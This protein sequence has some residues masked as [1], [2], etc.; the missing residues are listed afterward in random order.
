MYTHCMHCNAS[1][2]KNEVLE[3]FP[4]GERIAFD[5]NK[6]RLWVVCRK[7]E[8]W[9]LAPF[10]SRWEAIEQAERAYRSTNVRMATDNIGLAKWRDG[11]TLVRVGRPLRPEFAAWRYGDQFGRRRR[12]TLIGASV[13]AAGGVALVSGAVVSGVGLALLPLVHAFNMTMMVKNQRAHFTPLPHPDGDYFLPFGVPKLIAGTRGPDD[14]AIELGWVRRMPEPRMT[15]KSWIG[16]GKNYEQGR[17]ILTDALAR[18]ALAKL[19]V[20]VNSGGASSARVQDAVSMIENAGGP[21]QMMSWA[22]AQRN[23][24]GAKQNFGD[25]GDLQYIPTEAR[26]AI[27]MSVH[28]ERE[29]LALLGELAEL[30]RAWMDAERIANISDNLLVDPV[31]QQKFETMRD[32]HRD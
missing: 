25:T 12:R 21:D 11:T 30:E 17:V 8:R 26:L 3:A 10:E 9:N 20:R 5:E 4:V 22:V 24:W 27:E 29:R 15:L 13:L 2:G 14:W 31:T 19:L 1:L 16:N 32:Q 18:D 23:A 28:E 6:G 7:C